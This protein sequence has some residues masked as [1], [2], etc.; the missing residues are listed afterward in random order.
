MVCILETTGRDWG[1]CFYVWRYVALLGWVCLL[2]CLLAT[3]SSDD[4]LRD[5]MEIVKIYD[6]KPAWIA[7]Y[8]GMIIGLGSLHGVGIGGVKA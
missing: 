7:R 2:A 8:E 3:S 5:A 4:G 1:T 6:Y